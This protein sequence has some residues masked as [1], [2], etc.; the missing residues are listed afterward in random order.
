M[1]PVM[2]GIQFRLLQIED[3]RL[4]SIPVVVMTAHAD[5]Q[6]AKIKTGVHD[7]IRKP[8]DMQTFLKVV[9]NHC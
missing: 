6:S 1:M 5:I 8:S 3:P 9:G 7:I 2:D 4:S